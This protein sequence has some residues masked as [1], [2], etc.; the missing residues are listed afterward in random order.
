[1][2]STIGKTTNAPGTNS[3]IIIR[4][5]RMAR[6]S[7]CFNLSMATTSYADARAFIRS[8]G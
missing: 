1:M 2:A 8:H 7:Y 6:V 4:D 5:T 3:E